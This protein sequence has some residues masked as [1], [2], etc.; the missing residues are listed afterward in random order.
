MSNKLYDIIT[1]VKS[2]IKSPAVSSK[3]LVMIKEYAYEYAKEK[4]DA[5]VDEHFPEE[6]VYSPEEFQYEL[7]KS[8]R[9][10]AISKSPENEKQY[11]F[12]HVR[13]MFSN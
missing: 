13:F 5:F 6:K 8:I 3:L 2:H 11:F 1:V 7:Q 9:E 10:Y 4:F 12:L